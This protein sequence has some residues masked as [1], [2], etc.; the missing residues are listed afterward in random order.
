MDNPRYVV[1]VMIDEPKGNAY[2]SGQRTA[3]WT[4][5]PVVSK[6]V[7]RAGP[8]LGFSPTKAATSMFPNSPR[9]CGETGK[10]CNAA[11]RAVGRSKGAGA[12]PVVTGLAID[13][14]KAPGT[15]FGAFVGEK[16]NGEDFIPAKVEA[17]AWSSRGPKRGSKA[18]CILPS[19]SAPRFRAA[20]AARSPFPGDLRRG[21]G[22]QRRRDWRSKGSAMAFEAS[23]HGLISIALK[24]CR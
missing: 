7:M 12:D 13:H 5:A 15:I 21:D 24:V 8:M 2:S 6:V 20:I 14:R 23:S 17:G 11:V 1:L 10:A 19:Q 18:R 4:A 9:C 3:G 16:F 22:D